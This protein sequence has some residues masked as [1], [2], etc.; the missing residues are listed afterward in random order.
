MSA[1]AQPEMTAQQ[2]S[3]TVT[4]VVAALTTLC[5]STAM[6]GVIDGLRWLGYAGVAVIV[7]TATGLGLRAVRTPVV[8]VAFA[9]LFA[10]LCLLVA[11]FT[12]TGILGLLPGPAA[13]SELGDVLQRSVEVVRTGVPPV[14]PSAAVLC[15]VVIAIGLVAVLVDTLAVAAGTPAACGLVLLCVYAVPASLAD[16]MLPWWSFVLGAGSFALL[17]AVDGAHRHQ[18]WRNRP[19]M[20]GTGAGVGS[21]A[22]HVSAALLLALIAGSTITAIGTVGQLPGNAGTG[23]AGGLGLKPFTQLRGML[24]QGEN[25]ELFRVRGLGQD[26]R[27]MRAMTLSVYNRNGGWELRQP[28]PQGTPAGREL[29][30]PPG[31]REPGQFTTIDIETINYEDLFAGVYGTPRRIRNLPQGMRYDAGSGMVYSES[32]RRLARYRED[33]DLGQPTADDLRVA[34]TDYGDIDQSYLDNGDIDP[35]VAGLAEQITAGRSTPYDKAVALDKFFD[36]NR[37]IYALQTATGADEDALHDFLFRSRAGFCEQYAS[38]MAILARAAGLPSRVAIGYTGGYVIGDY[39]SITTKDAHAWVEIFFPGQGWIMFDPTPLNDGRAYTPPY[40]TPSGT[41]GPTDDPT[42]ETTTPSSPSSAGA[43]TPRDD[44]ADPDQGAAPGSA[45]QEGKPAWIGWTTGAIAL[46]ALLLSVLALLAAGGMLPG[47]FITGRRVLIPIAAICWLLSVVLAAALVSWWLSA[48]IVALTLAAAPGFVRQ[49]QRR[50]RRHAVH[51]NHALAASAAW[52][53]LM[54][55]TLDRGTELIRAETVRMTA[56]R[57]AR[58][59]DLDEDGKR[60][61]RTVVGA[62]ERSWYSARPDPDPALPSAFDDLVAGLH[63]TSPVALRARLFPR[64][65]LG[66]LRRAR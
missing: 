9:Q 63:R 34:G 43:A 25:R 11:L 31:S 30:L 40:A 51:R 29:P 44:R 52:Q 23:G 27:Y 42:A 65:V 35:E 5:A 57:L 12:N 2:W 26:G 37:F 61:L 8:L 21:P 49:W 33:V 10:V 45:P 36:G 54:A 14:E 20:P 22:T 60:A 18:Q 56:R 38:A 50:S 39:R 32:K 15:L 16:E 48:L 66:R 6:S 62:V 41:A 24:D 4:P 55:E 3:M 59:H 53:E 1:P 13:I 47:R 19:T 17:L 7:V 64:S 28:M 46:V 58:E